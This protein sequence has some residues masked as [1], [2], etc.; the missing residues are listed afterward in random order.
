MYLSSTPCTCLVR[1]MC[2]THSHTFA[3]PAHQTPA[4]HNTWP[5]LPSSAVV[6]LIVSLSVR[7]RGSR[8]SA[9]YGRRGRTRR[10]THTLVFSGQSRTHRVRF[11]S[12]LISLHQIMSSKELLI[13]INLI[14]SFP[15]PLTHR[16][17]RVFVRS[18]CGESAHADRADATHTF[19]QSCA[20]ALWP[21]TRLLF[22]MCTFH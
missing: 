1:S 15:K 16:H 7:Q 14:C 19:S 10:T 6:L 20:G 21:R 5:L 8:V 18:T 22:S 2:Y 4:A 17:V 13:F 11:T 3:R 9:L 12:A